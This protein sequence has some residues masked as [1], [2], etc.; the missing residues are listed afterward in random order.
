MSL[1]KQETSLE[2]HVDEKNNGT[3]T[4]GVLYDSAII[5]EGHT[6]SV[7]TSK[8]NQDGSLIATGGSNNSIQLWKLPTENVNLN[9]ASLNGHKRA[10]TSLC[11]LTDVLVS[12]SADQ[13]LGIWDTYTAQKLRKLVGHSSVIN[14]VIGLNETSAASVADDGKMMMWDYREKHNIASIETGLPLLT[15]CCQRGKNNN[16]IYL[17]GIN[18]QIVAFDIRNLK[19]E[20]WKFNSQLDTV[21]SLVTSPDGSTLAMRTFDGLVRT[22]NINR[23]P[24]KPPS[25]GSVLLGT[26]SG[27]H[28]CSIKAC[29]SNNNVKV[30]SGSE[31][32]TVIAW[33]HLSG[34]LLGK[35]QGHQDAVYEVDY[36]PKM[37][38]LLSCSADGTA[39]VR[40]LWQ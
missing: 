21:T 16:T 23:D 33:D 2:K 3:S 5:L 11:W 40:E 25:L 20:L 4:S 8:F 6:R 19:Q 22:Y 27:D 18:P 37:D 7:N 14:Q 13:S 26:P 12:A 36:H 15:A 9:I 38:I 32:G 35:Y 1:A 17:S 28:Y 31:D 10:V 29:F 30:L 39:I 24:S 34:S